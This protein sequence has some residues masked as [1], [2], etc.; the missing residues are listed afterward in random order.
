MNAWASAAVAAGA[1][2]GAGFWAEAVAARQAAVARPSKD[3]VDFMADIL[4]FTSAWRLMNPSP[5][6]V[7]GRGNRRSPGRDRAWSRRSYGCPAP[8][9]T[10]RRE[11]VARA[12]GP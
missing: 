11:A 2:A 9:R 4:S 5:G 10:E 1:L 12:P 7:N 6:A 3:I 8:R